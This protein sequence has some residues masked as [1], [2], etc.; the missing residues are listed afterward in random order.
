MRY[1]ILWFDLD[2]TLLNFSNSSVRA[3]TEL[4]KEIGLEEKEDSYAT[5]HKINKVE[6]ELFEQGK[7]TQDQLKHSRFQNYFD[8][9]GFKFDGLT[10][11]GI[12]LK[13]IVEFPS[14][15][16]GV[17]DLLGHVKAKGYNSSIVTNGMKEVQRPR[18]K[19]C[20]WEHHFQ[21]IFVSDEMGVAKPQI[22]F[23]DH[24]L[25][26]SGNPDKSDILIIGDT[27]KSDILGANRA[28]IKSCWINPQQKECPPD[29]IPD[30]EI[31]KL[32]DLK[33]II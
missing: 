29:I 5:Y 23:F 21:H 16:D 20:N 10:A 15:L 26:A 31:R 14:Y 11:N 2:N 19:K 1:P 6:W 25:N 30:Y 9:I 33:E 8:H 27:L 22:E 4:C 32:S 7:I 24:C 28:G 3:F 18:I 17:E 12:Y 13:Y